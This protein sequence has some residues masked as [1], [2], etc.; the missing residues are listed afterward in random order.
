MAFM[1]HPTHTASQSGALFSAS[2]LKGV[3]PLFCGLRTCHLPCPS[4]PQAGGGSGP[5]SLPGFSLSHPLP[6]CCWTRRPG[7]AW[8]HGISL[9]LLNQSLGGEDG[10]LLAVLTPSGNLSICLQEPEW[11]RPPTLKHISAFLSRIRC[12]FTLLS[13]VLLPGVSDC[14]C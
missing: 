14:W 12:M 2:H 1:Y 8:P 7:Y 10:R 11:P 13:S 6:S 4:S 9:A 5:V 3:R